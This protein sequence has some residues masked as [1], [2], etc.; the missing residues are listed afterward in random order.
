MFSIHSRVNRVSGFGT[1]ICIFVFHVSFFARWLNFLPP[2]LIHRAYKI[3]IMNWFFPHLFFS[4]L[5]KIILS[6]STVL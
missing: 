2:C 3:H 5:F 1:Y 4:I 6:S